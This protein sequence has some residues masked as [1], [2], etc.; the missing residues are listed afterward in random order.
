MPRMTKAVDDCHG[1]ALAADECM[2]GVRND[3]ST[4]TPM[5][6]AMMPPKG[7]SRTGCYWEEKHNININMT[8]T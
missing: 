3:S 8:M 4:P 5:K 1:V 2:Y 7:M 6:Q